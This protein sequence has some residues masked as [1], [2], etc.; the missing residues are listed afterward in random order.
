MIQINIIPLARSARCALTGPRLALDA[1]YHVAIPT[2]VLLHSL[3][4]T[5]GGDIVN[6][7]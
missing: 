7:K 4:R 5:V 1:L 2:D 6:Q 3:G